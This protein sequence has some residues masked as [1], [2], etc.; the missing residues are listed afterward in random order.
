MNSLLSRLLQVVGKSCVLQ[1]AL[2]LLLVGGAPVAAQT[3]DDHVPATSPQADRAEPPRKMF[4]QMDERPWQATGQ[5]NA[6]LQGHGAFHSPYEGTNSLRGRSEY[7]VSLVGTL[8][9]G[10]QPWQ[11]LGFGGTKAT[12]YN[13]DL[14]L[15]VESAGGRGISQALGLAGFTNLDVV[16]NPTLG[17]KPYLARVELHQ[18]VGFT[19]EMVRQDRTPLSM[20]TEV[21]V[22]RLDFRVG[23]MSTPDSFDLNTVLTDSHLQFTNWSIDNNGAWDY[24][25]DTRGYTYGA[26]LEYQD[27]GWAVR[28][29][30]MLMPTVANGTDLDWSVKRSRGQNAEVELRHGV[31]PGRGGVQRA[32]LFVNTAHMGNYREAVSAFRFRLDTTP[33][34]TAHEHT[35]ATKYGFGYNME[36]PLTGYVTLAARFGWNDGKTESYAYTEIEQTVLVGAAA[37]GAWWGRPADR[38]GVA[39]VSNAIKRDHQRYLQ[40]GGLGFILG[41]GG[42]RYGRETT[43]EAYYDLHMWRGLYVAPQMSHVNNPGYNQDRGP[44]WV[45][46]LRAHVDF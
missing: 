33:N 1:C 24:A 36:Q 16:R 9:L 14:I 15:H 40:A 6:I 30:L 12:R 29:G 38:V 13:T 7:K 41:D 3:N 34:I 8:F 17:S 23:K 2:I 26:V 46:G 28:Y 42:L 25:A 11:A 27:R 21:P 35:G 10:L 4:S 32:L 44:V 18:T 43:E 20:A 45:P 37:A 19:K 5:A 39:L 22:R 31:L